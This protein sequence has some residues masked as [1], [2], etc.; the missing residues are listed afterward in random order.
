MTLKVLPDTVR[1]SSLHVVRVY[2]AIR[3][4][5]YITTV[6]YSWGMKKWLKRLAIVAV[7]LVLLYI[8][9]VVG[10]NLGQTDRTPQQATV[11]A[12][13]KEPTVDELLKLVNAERAKVG[14]KPLTLDP[15]LIES[16]MFKAQHM[17]K[18][19]YFGHVAPGEKGNNGLDY[20]EQ[21]GVKCLYLSENLSEQ[22]TYNTSGAAIAG[23]K[24]SKPHYKAMVDPRYE[25]TGIGIDGKKVVQHFCDEK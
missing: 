5:D 3:N 17:N 23:W 6:W 8:G 12:E 25:S 2:S 7:P 24:S 22:G 18:Y 4:I 15:L 9:F 10:Y 11:Q 14:V 16:A 19:N 20:A 1:R 13:P 21:L